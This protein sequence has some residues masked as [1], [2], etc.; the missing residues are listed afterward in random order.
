MS[1]LRAGAVIGVAAVFQF[2]CELQF[3]CKGKLPEAF[4]LR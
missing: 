3:S 2:F 1:S 4:R